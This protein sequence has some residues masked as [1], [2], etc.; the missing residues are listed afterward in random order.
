M[1]RENDAAYRLCS[2]QFDAATNMTDQI[3]AL[4]LAVNSHH[5][6]RGRL[7][8]RFYAQW[9]R[10]AL[11]I[12]KWFALQASCS[13][14]DTLAAVV[15]LLQHPD[16][17]LKVPNRVR[18]LIGVF[19]QANPVNF[20]A[21]DGRGYE[22]LADHV[23]TLDGLNPQIAARLAGALTQWRRYDEQRAAL[24]RAQLQR[25]AGTSGISKDVY[26]VASKGLA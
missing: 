5:P 1:A 2:A 22:F 26:E 6:E 25:I 20:H 17:D 3:A 12:D 16:F 13:L 10:E 8:E 19:S 18:S 9:R 4:T 7:L 14:P 11:V 24:L 21:R 23:I 15:G